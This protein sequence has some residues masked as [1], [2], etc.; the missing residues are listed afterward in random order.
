MLPN[1]I[2]SSSQSPTFTSFG[3]KTA[4]YLPP[5]IDT[6]TPI[7]VVVA[8][9]RKQAARYRKNQYSE[10]R[11]AHTH[12]RSVWPCAAPAAR[13]ASSPLCV[14]CAGGHVASP[15]LVLRRCLEQLRRLFAD[16]AAFADFAVPLP[17]FLSSPAL[18]F[19]HTALSL[20]L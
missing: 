14:L 13:Y 7:R 12:T 3:Q 17:P 19:P 9:C 16:A 20:S 1:R 18:T 6:L 15:R 8:N 2:S 10:R 11:A 4:D 5:D